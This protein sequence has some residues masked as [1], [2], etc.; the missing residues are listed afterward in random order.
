MRLRLQKFDYC[1]LRPWMARQNPINIEKKIANNIS[2]EDN[3]N[4]YEITNGNQ[5]WENM[6]LP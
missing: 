6:E 5:H 3:Y 4:F 1:I 2:N